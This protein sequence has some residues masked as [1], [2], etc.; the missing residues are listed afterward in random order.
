[1]TT[2]TSLKIAIAQLNPTV[3]DIAGNV[4]KAKRAHAE[5]ARLGADLVVLP[6]L[7]LAGYSPEDLV[8]KPAFARAVRAATEQLASDL[9]PGGP[10]MLVGTLWPEDDGTPARK[11]YNAVA[12]IDGGKIEAIRT[13]VDLP[14]YGVFD[15]K[16]V[17]DAGALPSPINF[18]GIRIGAPICEDIWKEE[19]VECLAECGEVA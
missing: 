15:E 13:K 16:R 5:A 1:M 11:L 18:R 14:N 17:F 19:V 2:P 6:E 4:A 12:L 7:F 8:L 9:G 3:G 10:G